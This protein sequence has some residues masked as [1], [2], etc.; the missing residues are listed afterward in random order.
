MGTLDGRMAVISGAVQSIGAEYPRILAC[1]CAAVTL[2]GIAE[3][4]A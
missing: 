4:G 1:A 3:S 2:V